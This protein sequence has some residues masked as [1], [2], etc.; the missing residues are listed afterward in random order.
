MLLILTLALIVQSSDMKPVLSL[1]S[2][3]ANTEVSIFDSR[4]YG[5][6][7]WGPQ[8]YEVD[9]NECVYVHDVNREDPDNPIN[10]ILKFDSTGH[11]LFVIT[12]MSVPTLDKAWYGP[13]AIDPT[14]NDL[15]ILGSHWQDEPNY[16][17]PQQK[18]W[19]FRF[20]ESGEFREAK[21]IGVITRASDLLYDYEGRFYSKY[22]DGGTEFDQNF[23]VEREIPKWMV[24]EQGYSQWSDWIGVATAHEFT[25]SD[26]AE[27]KFLTGLQNIN[28]GKQL[29][30]VFYNPPYYLAGAGIEG[31]DRNHNVILRGIKGN[32]LRINPVTKKVAFVNIYSLGVP[33]GVGDVRHGTMISPDG[34]L[35]QARLVRNDMEMLE[36]HIYRISPD[37]FTEVECDSIV[38]KDTE[39]EK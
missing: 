13:F 2:G 20:S 23:M 14:T 26:A 7:S 11:F 37:M 38:E 30:F 24:A 27:G 19:F 12:P 17:I 18:A 29:R 8:Q 10:R 34:Y 5:D 15:V 39:G 4:E 35:Y 22:V 25:P 6:M 21:E 1:A 33:R 36:Y 3:K 9:N 28:T 16:A 31:I 32:F